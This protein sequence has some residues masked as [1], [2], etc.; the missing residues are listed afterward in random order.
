MFEKIDVNGEKAHSIY[1]F[2]KD[3]SDLNGEKVPHNFA[4][5][6]VNE[7]GRVIKYFKPGIQPLDIYTEHIRPL[8]N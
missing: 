7:S 1:K 4:K 2:M 3:N 5:F 8:L 6:L